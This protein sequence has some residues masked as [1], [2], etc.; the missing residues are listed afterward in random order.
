LDDLLDDLADNVGVGLQKIIA[1]H[2]GFARQ[3]GRNNTT[4]ELAVSS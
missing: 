2:S 3:P 1:A 4:S